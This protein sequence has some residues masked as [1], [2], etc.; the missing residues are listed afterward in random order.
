M[1]KIQT[2]LQ[3]IETELKRRL[4]NNART[5][6]DYTKGWETAYSEIIELVKKELPNER[7]AFEKAIRVTQIMTMDGNC[8]IKTEDELA[9]FYFENTFESNES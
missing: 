1:N 4:L 2:P 6:N 3:K 8:S 7:E 5:T 9:K